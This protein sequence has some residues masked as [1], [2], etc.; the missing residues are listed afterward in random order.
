MLA[1]VP[2]WPLRVSAVMSRLPSPECSM[3]PWRLSRVVAATCMSPPAARVPLALLS[4][5][6]STL[7]VSAASPAAATVPPWLIRLPASTLVLPAA[8]SWPLVLS[9]WPVTC[10]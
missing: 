10:T 2:A 5:R 9:S 3:A 7:T 8:T 4:S 1:M 6:S